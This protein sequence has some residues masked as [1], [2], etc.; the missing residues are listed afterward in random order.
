MRMRGR[1]YLCL[2]LLLVLPPSLSDDDAEV[3]HKEKRHK[4]K[5]SKKKSKHKDHKVPCA[6]RRPDVPE[7]PA[8]HGFTTH[9]S[10]LSPPLLC[11]SLH[12]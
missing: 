11:K 2:S 12:T 6:G 7:L 1:P 5:K 9:R 3:K 8:A 4:H 10:N